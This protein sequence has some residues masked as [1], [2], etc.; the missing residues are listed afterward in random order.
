MLTLRN[1]M[2]LRKQGIFSVNAIA[3][4]Y[5]NNIWVFDEQ[6]FTLK[7]ISEQGKLLQQTNDMRMFPGATPQV[8]SITD[9]NNFV[10][11]YDKALGFFVFDYYG[12]YKSNLPF[13]NWANISFSGNNLYGFENNRLHVY[14][15]QLQKEAIYKMPQQWK[16]CISI[17]AMNGK[18]YILKKISGFCTH[19]PTVWAYQVNLWPR[20]HPV[21]DH[22]FLDNTIKSYL[23]VLGVILAVYLLKKFVT[24]SIANILYYPVKLIWKE[25]DRK[26]FIYL[27]LKPL[28]WFILIC[29]ALATISRLNYPQFLDFKMQKRT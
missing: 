23:V 19:N 2:N 15:T 26:Q 8:S 29:V 27:L 13:K 25:I 6:D 3:N 21:L 20:N 7:K 4:A 17:K 22:Y 14:R 16:D 24:Q 18:I 12:T 10:Y 1:S 5:D 28:G 9:H 11:L